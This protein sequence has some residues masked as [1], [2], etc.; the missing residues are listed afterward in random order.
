MSTARRAPRR[1]P[2]EGPAGEPKFP[3]SDILMTPLRE[4][5]LRLATRVLA[6]AAVAFVL[7]HGVPARADAGPDTVV[8]TIDGTPITEG[9][10]AAAAQEF[11]QQLAQI[12]PEQR[13][14][15]LIQI[16]VELRLAATAAEK[17][18]LDKNAMV[19]THLAFVRDRVLRSEY[20]REKV[21][22]NVNDAAVKKR[23]DEQVAKF[24]PE[25]EVHVSHILVKTEAEAKAVIA[26]LDK[27]GDFAAI[28]KEKSQDPGS[29]PSGG[30]IGFIGKGKTVKP[31]EDAAFALE[32]GKY[33]ETPVQTQ[34]GWHVIKLQEK[35]KQPAPTIDQAA[36][37]IRQ[38]LIEETVEAE[39]AKLK[40]AAKIDIV[41]EAPAPAP[42]AP[43]AT[44][45]APAA[46]DA[47]APAAPADKPA[48]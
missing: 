32:V 2:P 16:L 11:G 30:D 26:D 47:T 39:L 38:Q 29:A 9:D 24:V 46:P 1:R 4:I 27:G 7:G 48:Q 41:P 13:R 15:T 18:G 3:K 45:P 33:T 31:F 25:D 23:F 44:A 19:A 34:F 42:A 35:R 12:P 10:L 20:L 8:A 17:E 21:V 14:A 28:A 40:A 5:R 22:A 43:D 36:P 6:V 37:G